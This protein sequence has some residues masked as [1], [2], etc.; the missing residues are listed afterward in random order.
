M[1]KICFTLLILFTLAGVS[2]QET[3]EKVYKYYDGNARINSVLELTDGYLL[4]GTYNTGEYG[5][6]L[7]KTNQYGDS[8]WT[9]KLNVPVT[10]FSKVLSVVDYQNNIYLT[11]TQGTND[12]IKVSPEGA[13]LWAKE[14]SASSDIYS[15]RIAPDNNLLIA[16]NQSNMTYLLKLDREGN[17]VWIS[18]E[19][20]NPAPEGQ[21]PTAL[22]ALGNGNILLAVSN[23]LQIP[24]NSSLYY[25][26]A[27]GQIIST[28]NLQASE[29]MMMN[30]IYLSGKKIISLATPANLAANNNR[31]FIIEHSPTGI[32]ANESKRTF[33]YYDIDVIKFFANSSVNLITLATAKETESSPE[34]I[35]LYAS[36]VAGDSLWT[37]LL[38]GPGKTIAY[39]IQ[40]DSDGGYLISASIDDNG[41]A[42]PYFIKTDAAGNYSHLGIETSR[43]QLPVSV[44][45]NPATSVVV[46]QTPENIKGSIVI[47]DLQGRECKIAE[48]N[49]SR[50]EVETGNMLPGMYI[51]T[52]KSGNSIRTGKI[53]V[54]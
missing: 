20:L 45:P 44:Y 38:G 17:Q 27:T 51:Y 11:T 41:T 6:F 24:A 16:Y 25:Y 36:N 29:P 49:G 42:R 2:A 28:S 19:I 30:D 10:G 40:P 14:V 15:L 34:Q 32:V 12:I 5:I 9:K 33:D 47:S 53:S 52:I 23:N 37:K 50:T 26:S 21:I 39:D 54:K 22:N 48:I 1:K 4:A 31:L 43:E 7:I 8:L 3:F 13:V 35:M 46:F 18:E